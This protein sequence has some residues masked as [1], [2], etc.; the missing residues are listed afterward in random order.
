MN[1][2]S[3]LPTR[4]P[5]RYRPSKAKAFSLSFR[6]LVCLIFTMCSCLVF[7]VWLTVPYMIQC[8]EIGQS[9]SVMPRWNAKQTIRRAVPDTIVLHNLTLSRNSSLIFVGGVPRS[10]TTLFRAMLDAHPDVRCGEETRIVP[11]L[12]FM[13]QRWLN[14]AREKERL[15]SAGVTESVINEAL[16]SFILEVIAKHGEPAKRFCDKDPLALKSMDYLNAVFPNARF[17]LMLRD[18]RAVANSIVQRRVRIQG[19]DSNSF[20]SALTFWNNAGRAMVYQCQQL[21]HKC[22]TVRYEDLVR[23]SAIEMKRVLQFLN[24]PWSPAVLHHEKAIGQP[25]G[26]SLSQ[27]EPSYKQVQE[28]IYTKSLREWEKN[29]PADMTNSKMHQIA[30]LLRELGYV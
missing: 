9:D 7:S 28:P 14:D 5:Q 23:F 10:G 18:G 17:V 2:D 20:E 15:V 29:I 21:Q 8:S 26:V 13:R 12:L 25:G 6:G 30:P 11:R 24:L 22:V 27:L 4:T 19:V 16:A 1:D 3:L